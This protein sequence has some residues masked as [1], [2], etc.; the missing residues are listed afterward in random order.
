MNILAKAEK[1]IYLTIE[2]KKYQRLLDRIHNRKVIYSG[3]NLR[4]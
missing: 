2:V 4:N 1:K 3:I